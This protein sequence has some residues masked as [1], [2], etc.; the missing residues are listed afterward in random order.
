MK[1]PLNV[2]FPSKSSV[3]FLSRPLEPTNDEANYR[4]KECKSRE[5]HISFEE[6]ERIVFDVHGINPVQR[7]DPAMVEE[8]LKELDRE[9]NCIANKQAYDLAVQV[10]A[11]YPGSRAFRLKFLRCKSFDAEAAAQMMVMHFDFKRR[12]FGDGPILLARE[13]RQS[14]LSPQDRTVLEASLVQVLRS[15]DAGGRA[16]WLTSSDK[17]KS[18]PKDGWEPESGV[19]YCCVGV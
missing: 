9:L 16:I 18:F 6:R 14:D 2:I 12:I 1:I 19:S 10:D 15:R 17:I 13:A 7:E 5:R 3:H 8:K 4:I 11:T